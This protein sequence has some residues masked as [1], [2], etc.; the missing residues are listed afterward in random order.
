M[1]GIDVDP[2]PHH[3]GGVEL[4]DKQAGYEPEKV[5]VS[6]IQGTSGWSFYVHIIEKLQEPFDLDVL[7]APHELSGRDDTQCVGQVGDQIAGGVCRIDKASDLESNHRSVDRDVLLSGISPRG[8]NTYESDE[9]DALDRNGDEEAHGND[10][11]DQG[12][13]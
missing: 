12:G 10:C 5:G 4:I 13:R 8:I 7:R 1:A 9:K 6:V 3:D 11:H 2:F